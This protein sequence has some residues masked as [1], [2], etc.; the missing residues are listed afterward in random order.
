MYR[1]FRYPE[2]STCTSTLGLVVVYL[3]RSSNDLIEID[4][5]LF[6][7][8]CDAGIR[9]VVTCLGFKVCRSCRLSLTLSSVSK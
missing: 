2:S 7:I 1:T 3:I 8:I 6:Y 9:E 5:L 4:F